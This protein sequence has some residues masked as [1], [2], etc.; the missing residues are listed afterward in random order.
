MDAQQQ[1]AERKERWQRL[2]DPQQAPT[3]LYLIHYTPDEEPQPHLW[4]RCRQERIEWSWRKYQRQLARLEWLADDALPYLDMLTGTEIFAEAFGC[5]V[6]RPE[7]TNPYAR[8][9]I[10]QARQVSALKVPEVSATPLAALFEMAD[11]LRRRAGPQALVRL[12]DVQSPMDIAALIWDK[13][14]FYT[15]MLETP[16][17]VKELAAKVSQLWTQF[18]DEWLRRYGPDF[19]A[20]FPTY[21]MPKGVTLSED[22]IGAVSPALYEEFFLPELQAIS[23]HFGGLGLHCCAHARHQWAGL[24][25]IPNLRLLNLVQPVEVLRQA[26]DYFAGLPQMHSWSGEGDPW[27]WP[28]QHPKG[29]RMVMEMRAETRDEALMLAERMAAACGRSL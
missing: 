3:S 16:E 19:V 14:T 25:R 1:I 7:D 17:A 15:A 26:W 18:L 23:D 27:T 20:H 10:T 28:A 11:E 2:L 5:P 8:P 12:V 9:L 24:K 13:N 22:E 29:S 21:Y 6:Y 4:L